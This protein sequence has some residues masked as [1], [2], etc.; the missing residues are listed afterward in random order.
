M[1]I[2]TETYLQRKKLRA[3][4]TLPLEIAGSHADNSESLAVYRPPFFRTDQ[5]PLAKPPRQ[6]RSRTGGEPTILER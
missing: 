2:Q 1:T 4:V 6:P 3:E 5:G